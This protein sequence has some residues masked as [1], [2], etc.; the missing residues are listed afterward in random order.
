[1]KKKISTS[2]RNYTSRMV[3]LQGEIREDMT[4][5]LVENLL[6]LDA[7]KTAPIVLMIHS[8]GGSVREMLHILSAIAFLRS[9]VLCVC[10][11]KAASAAGIVL[12]CGAKQGN[13]YITPLSQV[14]LHD[15]RNNIS[16]GITSMSNSLS[17]NKLID[18][19]MVDFKE[20]EWVLKTT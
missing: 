16:G 17:N 20:L 9:D 11:G 4:N 5:R 6:N 12:A 14:L 1:M 15:M 13:R 3:Y 8:S 19:Q 18:C 10:L 7:Q 2:E